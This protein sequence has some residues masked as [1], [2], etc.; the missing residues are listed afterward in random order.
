[1]GPPY[2]AAAASDDDS[3]DD[4]HCKPSAAAAGDVEILVCQAGSCARAGG[5]AVLLE[6][7]ELAKGASACKVEGSGCLGACGQAPNAVVVK[8]RRGERLFTRVTSVEKSADIIAEATGRAPDL[9]DEALRS[10][11]GAARRMRVRQTARGEGK[12]NVAMAGLAEQVAAADADDR[13]E[14]QYELAQLCI[15][16]GQCERALELLVEMEAAVGGG[17]PMILME[18]GKALA[19]LGRAAE[20][21]A[22]AAGVA[23]RRVAAELSGRLK[24]ARGVAAGGVPNRI[25]GYALWT[26]ASVTPASAH[27]AVYRLTSTDRKRGTPYTRGRGRTMWHKTWHTTLL[28]AVGENAEG[29]LGYV[30]RDYTPVSGWKEW[31]AGVVDLLV[32]VYPD[33]AATSWLYRQPIGAQLWLSQP[34]KTLHVPSLAADNSRLSN[35]EKK[36]DAVLL[37]LG[38]TGIVAAPQVLSHSDPSTCFGTSATGMCNPPLT[39]P[40]SLVYAC[41][42]DDVLLP[43]ELARW[44]AAPGG[45]ARLERCVLA[46][47]PAAAAADAAA[48]ADAAAAAAPFAA[49]APPASAAALDA[50]RALPNASVVEGR[51]TQELVDGE[52]ARARALGACRVVVSGP[53]AFNKAVKTMLQA[54]GVERGRASVLEA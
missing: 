50:L 15:S 52:L 17:H 32:K 21:E 14:L 22:L 38:G 10:R 49:A 25:D 7:E 23:H 45:G 12:W 6:I 13:L 46:V 8:K 40:I 9:D 47:S 16:A 26:L 29:P 30:E 4:D 51:V 1:M 19:K 5:E 36:N 43:A 11:L 37:I 54:A 28:A 41:R 18:K 31:E 20:I 2:D 53:E 33:G 48:D 44:C 39:A 35:A 24:E 3:A 42:S 34:A 27:S